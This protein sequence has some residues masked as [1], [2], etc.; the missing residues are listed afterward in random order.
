M[1]SRLP[2]AFFV[3]CVRSL[4][5]R[6]RR[7]ALAFVVAAALAALAAPAAE[8][9]IEYRVSLADSASNT[10]RVTMTVP[11]VAGDLW[12][13]MPAWNALYQIRDFAHRIQHV[14]ATA[15]GAPLV[16]T[17]TDKQTWTTTAI[18]TVTIEYAAFW[19]QPGAFGS[20]LTAE[21]A[22]LNLAT[23]LFYVPDRREEDVRVEFTDVPAGWRVAVAL[24]AESPARFRAA[25]YD[26]L[27]DAPVEISAFDEFRFEVAGARIRVAV[28]GEYRRAALEDTLRR[29]VAY[30][31]ELMGGAPFKEFL[32]LF[33][34]GSFGGGGMEH[35]NSTAI[36]QASDRNPA[37]IS[38]HEF[39]H[40]WNVK[41]IRPASLEPVNYSREQYTRA[42]WFA[43]GVTSTYA[44]YTL[45]RTGLWTAERFY[46]S[47]AGE[48]TQLEARPAR[49]WKSVEE[50]SLD[51]WLEKYQVHNRSEFSISYYNKGQLLGVLLDI[52]IRDATD[53]RRS[54]DDVLR[55]MNDHYAKAGRYYDDSA[56]VR[57]A[58][59]AV[60]AGAPGEPP[61]PSVAD[62]FAHY[63]AG[64]HPLPYAEFLARAGLELRADGARYS[65]TETVRPT[66]KQRRIRE[67][68]LR[69]ITE[70]R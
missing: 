40:L 13:A 48:I 50:A 58:V 56:G 52:L 20:E 3:L 68:I 16:V 35:A 57:A 23:L 7:A 11:D 27:V 66:D 31:V 19:D 42:L 14:R 24:D 28:H 67:G 21:H 55:W 61:S 51:A 53:N 43:E 41:R 8:A 60:L 39:F 65:V 33:H 69:G 29:I 44:D 54:L 45:V 34:F 30:Q 18:G 17:K 9:T 70:R 5:V 4:S 32:F 25:N 2:R 22:F 6:A 12:L 36:N 10:L 62:F 26:A 37:P 1:G 49:E 63:V 64:T 59:E 46:A 38:A 47:L 15:A